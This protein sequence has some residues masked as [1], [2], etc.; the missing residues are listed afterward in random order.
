M[1]IGA[2]ITS[3]EGGEAELL[4]GHRIPSIIDDSGFPKWGRLY[5]Q[6]NSTQIH[7]LL[8]TNLTHRPQNDRYFK[9]LFLVQSSSIE[10]NGYICEKS[11]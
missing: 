1:W 11:S 10:K 7:V 4:D 9:R 5:P 3:K 2:K 6:Y 8:S